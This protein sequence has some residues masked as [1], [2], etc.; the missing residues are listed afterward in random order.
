MIYILFIFYFY[1]YIFIKFIGSTLANKITQV[2]SVH[3]YD[4]SIFIYLLKVGER[5]SQEVHKDVQMVYEYLKECSALCIIRE[6]HVPMAIRQQCI[7]S[8]W[9]M[10]NNKSQVGGQ[11]SQKETELVSKNQVIYIVWENATIWQV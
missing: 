10:D 2:S 3:F 6:K 4:T 5:L 8:M 1:F 11:A 7:T 9:Q